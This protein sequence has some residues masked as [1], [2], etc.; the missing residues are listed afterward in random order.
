MRLRLP[1]AL[2]T[3]LCLQINPC[4]DKESNRMGRPISVSRTA[5]A[6]SR[7]PLLAQVLAAATYPTQVVEAD[8]VEP[9][10]R[11]SER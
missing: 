11:K 3:S 10:A 2:P 5:R 1:V 4:L 9:G 7:P 6:P 8:P